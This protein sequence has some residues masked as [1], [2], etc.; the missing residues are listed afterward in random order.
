MDK[1]DEKAS[2][3]KGPEGPMAMGMGMAKKM[4]SQIGQGGSPFEMVQK[5]MAQMAQGDTKPPMEKM[6]G[7]CM[8]M[9]SE[10]LNAIRQTNALAVHGTPE[11][12]AAFT[13][14]LKRYEEKALVALNEG[15][16]DA[17]ALAAVLNVSEESARYVLAQPSA[18]WKD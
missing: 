10:M 6:M 2:Q 9:C 17:T 3:A 8:G 16:K 4:M 13:D 11:L 7:M 5:M 14:W 18:S 15:E 12:H 1:Q